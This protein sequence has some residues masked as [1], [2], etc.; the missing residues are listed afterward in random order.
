MSLERRRGNVEG[1]T[2]T[3]PTHI[4]RVWKF[5]KF[6]RFAQSF[7]SAA[8]V[9]VSAARTGPRSNTLSAA[10]QKAGGDVCVYIYM[11]R[12]VYVYT[13]IYSY[14]Y[15]YSYVF[16]FMYIYIYITHRYVYMEADVFC[17][18]DFQSAGSE[19]NRL[20]IHRTSRL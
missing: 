18:T 5:W 8:V 16:Y 11:C 14:I 7:H 9:A 17:K 3:D 20:S 2:E 6:D 10:P 1:E 12:Y 15:S 13:Y 4:V 19:S